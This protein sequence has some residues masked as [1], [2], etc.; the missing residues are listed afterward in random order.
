LFYVVKAVD[1]VELSPFCC[2]KGAENG[3]I[4]QF[5]VRAQIFFALHHDV[6]HLRDLVANLR[7]HLV[8]WHTAGT[9]DGRGF[10]TG[11]EVTKTYDN[12]CAAALRP[13]L[14]RGQRLSGFGYTLKSLDGSGVG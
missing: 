13:G 4:E 14:G 6:L 11:R 9:D 7:L 2:G 1:Q 10:A 8:G 5:A 3:M 12:E